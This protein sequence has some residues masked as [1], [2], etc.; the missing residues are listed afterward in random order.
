MKGSSLLTAVQYG[1]GPIGARIVDAATRQGIEFVGAIDIDP[2][3]VG[4]DLGEVAG[5]GE[6]LDVSITDEPDV[7]LAG[8]VDI[9]FLATASSL[10]AVRPQLR[11]AIV[12]GIDIVSTCEQ[13]TYP[14]YRNPELAEELDSL[15]SKHNAT[16]LGTGINPGFS[17]DLLP[18][19]LTTPCHEV[20]KVE[21]ERIQ[22]AATR[23]KPLQEKVG[24]GMTVDEFAAEILG[25]E[26][27]IGLTESVAMIADALGFNLDE[28]TESGEP[29]IAKE[30]IETDDVRVSEGEVAGMAQR[31]VGRVN[32]EAK[33]NLEISQ[34]VGADDPRD[35]TRIT[36]DPSFKMEIPGGIHGDTA[37]PA[38]V[39]NSVD[40]VSNSR[41][42]LMTMIDGL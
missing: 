14:W 30:P 13:L 32:G 37:T 1:V 35:E 12:R 7:V 40:R 19:V 4:A 29:V 16:V 27:H 24:A 42:G 25:E 33:I 3:K 26:G 41:P 9:V 5:L 15:A 10:E 23:R 31:G 39:V 20:E 2:N 28:I 21:V 6:H 34:Y 18:T 38:I 17:M 11:E 22:D 36:G 8:D